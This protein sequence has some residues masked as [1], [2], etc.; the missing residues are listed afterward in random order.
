MKVLVT[1]FDPFGGEPINPALETI[2]LLPSEIAGM[3]IHTLEIPTSAYKS[4]EIVKSAVDE[5]NPDIVLSIGQAGGRPDITVEQVGINLNEFRIADNAGA[6]P[7]DE[8]V[9]ADGPDAYL[10]KLPVKKMVENNRKQ[11]IPASIS[12]TAGTFVCNHVLY[13]VAYMLAK[14]G[15]GQKNGFIHIPFLPNQ[16]LDKPGKPSMSQQDILKGIIAAIEVLADS[17]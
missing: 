8:P 14:R 16:V 13:G 4:L 2:K 12:Y 15:Q 3:E 5:I 7:H 11:N 1:G 10:V 6:Q 9:F 17:E